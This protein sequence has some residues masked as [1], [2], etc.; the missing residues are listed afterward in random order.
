MVKGFKAKSKGN[1]TGRAG[2]SHSVDDVPKYEARRFGGHRVGGNLVQSHQI[3][4]PSGT[5]VQP[6]VGISSGRGSRQDEDDMDIDSSSEHIDTAP[7]LTSKEKQWASWKN[8]IIPALIQPYANLLA[9]TDNLAKLDQVKQAGVRCSGCVK[10][11][12]APV[13]VICLHFDK[14]LRTNEVFTYINT[15]L[16]KHHRLQ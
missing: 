6:N 11:T 15:V 3:H 8:I 9:S 1:V 13:T 14:E 7:G 4:T 10:G 16:T 12:G 5:F 2:T